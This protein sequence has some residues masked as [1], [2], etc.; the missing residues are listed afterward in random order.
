MIR[1]TVRGSVREKETGIGLAGVRVTSRTG[2]KAFEDLMGSSYSG[3]DGIFEIAVEGSDFRDFFTKRPE[4]FFD[5]FTADSKSP[6]HSTPKA[7]EWEGTSLSE[8]LVAVARKELG[9]AA[10]VRAVRVAGD[11]VNRKTLE[12]GEP[13]VVGVT[14]LRP[15]VAHRIRVSDA[16]P[17][18]AG[19]GREL[20]TAQL[21]ADA[22]GTIPDTVLWGQVGMDDPVTGKIWSVKEARTRWA[23]HK[24]SIEVL[25]GDRVV[26]KRTVTIAKVFA[27]SLVLSID[28]KGRPLNGFEI[29]ASPLTVAVYNLPAV[30][31]VSV[32]LYMVAQQGAWFVGNPIVP[33]LLASGRP[34][35]REMELTPGARDV[36]VAFA[37]ADELVP[38][39]YDFIVRPIRY[40]YEDD[41]MQ[42]EP[43]D[44]IANQYTTGVVVREP[45]MGS[46]AVEGGCV[47]TQ[48]MAS[49][50]LDE[51][52]YAAYTNVFQRGEDVWAALDP[53]A[54]YPL[55]VGKTTA[56]HVIQ[57]KTVAQWAISTGVQHLPALGG[58]NAVPTLMTQST[59]INFNRVLVWPQAGTPGDYDIVADFGSNVLNNQQFAADHRYDTPLDIIDGYFTP[60]FRV[61][62]DPGTTTTFPH[63]GTFRY[64]ETTQGT[65]TVTSDDGF[66]LSVRFRGVVYFPSSVAGAISP[67]QMS[68]AQ[69]SY[70]MVMVVPG[71]GRTDNYLG[72]NYLLEHLA[73]N[74][75]IAVCVDVPYPLRVNDRATVML[76]H[77]AKVRS[78]FHTGLFGSRAQNNIGLIGHSVGGDAVVAAARLNQQGGLGHGITAVAS[79]VPYDLDPVNTLQG[80]WS[81][82][83]LVVDGTRNGLTDGM[84]FRKYDRASG[85]AKSMMYL[86]GGSHWAYNTVDEGLPEFWLQPGDYAG[87]L[88]GAA[89]RT[90]AL[91]YMNAFMRQHLKADTRW[92]GVFNGEWVP[93]SVRP[94]NSSSV[95]VSAQYEDTNRRVVDNFEGPHT[96]ASWAISTI[97]GAVV[98]TNLPA[99]PV[100]AAASPTD[101]HAFHQ[102]G[103]LLFRWDGPNQMLRF[104]LPASQRNVAQYSAISFRMG[105]K[106]GG[107]NA[108]TGLLDFR[109]T[110]TDGHGNSR[111]IRMNKFGSVPWVH[112]RADNNRSIT[113]MNTIRIPL[114][115]YVVRCA[116]LLEV[117][118]T[119]IVNIT[120]D[121]SVNVY[122]IPSRG[123]VLFDSLEFT[124]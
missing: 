22:R 36:T 38:G 8:V 40:G 12:P 109:I 13:L 39:A 87:R 21:I 73:R 15:M 85:S 81:K 31:A 115:A 24:L 27:R 59:C 90:F 76:R 103:V 80:A 70:P 89:H 30:D 100:E 106:V 82:P 107:L 53:R 78:M 16:A 43:G 10:P 92:Q 11:D 98:A 119:N 105:R 44:V 35:V 32:R 111:G 2:D 58:N 47:N 45:F 88:G 99:V 49:R 41:H 122:G 116:G 101:P 50:W 29:G 124:M 60:G 79:L 28:A 65:T 110:L 118:L 93:A 33:V 113:A 102:S 68:W 120:F 1:F 84:G 63:A 23:G 108:T 14:G 77:I 83:Y 51:P 19:V 61:V 71:D 9:D 57:S 54:L 112:T 74:G 91:A 46:K 6:I 95:V 55:Q 20:F 5:V 3:P 69:A 96:A 123:E 117:D 121:F 114:T 64:T 75:F 56:L 66:P 97:G 25:D 104:D 94:I 67:Y 34:A 86:R 42:V 48:Q 4:I 18:R 62:D 17:G 52:P 26:L 7:A 72:F 37:G